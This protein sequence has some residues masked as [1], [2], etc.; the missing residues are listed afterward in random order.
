M[1][2]SFFGSDIFSYKVLQGIFG[3]RAVNQIQVYCPPPSTIKRS[4]RVITS[5]CHLENLLSPHH[6]VKYAPETKKD[7]LKDLILSP[8]TLDIGIVASYGYFIPENIINSF[9]QG[10]INVHPSL[11]PLYQGA[12]PIQHTISD[13]RRSTGVS[14]IKISPRAFDVG[15]ILL[16]ESFPNSIDCETYDSLVNKL[17]DFSSQLI[18]K[19]LDNY[20][21]YY[22]NSTE[23]TG[24]ITQAPKLSRNESFVDWKS[25]SSDI[26]EARFRAFSSTV[27]LR[28]KLGNKTVLIRSLTLPPLLEPA[29]AIQLPPGSIVY[30][31][32]NK[33]LRVFCSHGSVLI[34]SLQ[35]ESKKKLN[36][37]EFANGYRLKQQSINFSY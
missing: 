33:A 26:V 17:G 12:C 9:S 16:Q 30:D 27:G 8:R 19:V 21:Y 4:H 28:T 25:M 11:L 7:S 6:T 15:S 31:S 34:Q 10:M 1:N 36:A 20:Q 35:V 29:P 23:Q 32:L 2:I 24:D 14:I 5:Q 22:N 13:Q 18:S 37:Q 3:H